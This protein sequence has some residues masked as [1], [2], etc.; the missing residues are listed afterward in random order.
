ERPVAFMGD[1]I[2]TTRHIH[3]PYI[4][5]YD[6]FPLTT[7]HTRK[8]IYRRAMEENWLLVFEHD[9]HPHAG[10]LRKSGDQFSLQLL[11]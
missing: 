5:A 10:T 6:L 8:E 3:L 11:Y 2:P 7:L 4:M 1:L 9:D